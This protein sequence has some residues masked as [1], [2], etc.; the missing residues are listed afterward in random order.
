MGEEMPLEYKCRNCGA[1]LDGET[2]SYCGSRYATVQVK[3]PR[4]Y[5]DAIPP[6]R[7]AVYRASQRGC[8]AYRGSHVL[9]WLEQQSDKFKQE[10]GPVFGA[11]RLYGIPID[12]GK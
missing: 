5:M 9:R 6:D 3:G 2:C 7:R 8:P 1:P 12:W 11:A 10:I 4:V